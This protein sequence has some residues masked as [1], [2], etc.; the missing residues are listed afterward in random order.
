MT[1]KHSMYGN[2]ST[3]GNHDKCQQLEVTERY[4]VLY[5]DVARAR[6]PRVLNLSSRDI[7]AHIS[8]LNS[9]Q[10]TQRILHVKRQDGKI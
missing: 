4:Q 10:V 8:E 3:W 1:N 5:F 6:K 2:I 9:T 7:D